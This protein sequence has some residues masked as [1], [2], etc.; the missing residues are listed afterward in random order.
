MTKSAIEE[1][2]APFFEVLYEDN[3]LIGV[4]KK[5]GVPVQGDS[6][7]D[8]PLTE[9][10]KEYLGEVYQKPGNVFC[11]LIHRLDRP[12][13]GLTLLAKTSKGLERMNEL[14][15]ERQIKKTYMA[16]VCA[17]PEQESGT[18]VH[19]LKKD[20]KTNKTSAHQKEVTDSL[21]AE[22]SYTLLESTDRYH[23]LK[24]EPVTGR[25][26]QIRAQLAA[27][28]CSIKGDLKYGAPRSN[29]DGSI[30]LHAYQLDFVHP[31]K[32]EALQIR[33]P[34]PSSEP[35]KFLKGTF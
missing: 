10:V 24:V 29:P 21:R 31:I 19:W 18:L 20:N 4:F 30:S 8:T 27:I 25:G 9:Y 34:L 3:H 14:F 15:R 11:G 6:T 12:V 28:G 32:N 26:H 17:K 23:L 1:K 16:F 35:W 5:S 13:S 33:C 7:G 2:F 22:L